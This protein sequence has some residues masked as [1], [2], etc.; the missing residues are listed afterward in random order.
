MATMKPWL[1]QTKW[2]FV[3]KPPR[4]RP[5][6]WSDGSC[7][8]AAFGPPRSLGPLK[9]FFRPGRRSACPDDGA[10]D[11]PEV[12]VD[13]PSVVQSIQQRGDDAGP[14]A[15]LAP[16]VEA[17]EDRLPGAIAFREIAPRG[18]GM[19]DPEDAIDDRT[20]II[21][22]V[23]RPTAMRPVWQQRGD[24]C[25]LRVGEFVAAHG[26]TRLGGRPV[27]SWGFPIIVGPP[28]RRQTQ[29][30]VRLTKAKQSLV[31]DRNGEEQRYSFW[32][33]DEAGEERIF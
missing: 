14:G 2:I 28:T 7:I 15:V 11:T 26:R 10:I 4:E 1:S 20:G 31:I 24:A 25:P 12:V 3:P 5:N 21:E 32:A 13:L 23:A 9:F 19:E 27:C 6:A 30:S 17:R 18:A 33:D 16:T 22:R 29:I 8:C